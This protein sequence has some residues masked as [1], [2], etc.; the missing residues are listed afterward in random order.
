MQY[1]VYVHSSN[2]LVQRVKNNSVKNDDKIISR[3]T[4]ASFDRIFSR[5]D[6]GENKGR[7]KSHDN[8]NNNKSEE[9][10]SSISRKKRTISETVGAAVQKVRR[11][12]DI[13]WVIALQYLLTVIIYTV[14]VALINDGLS[15]KVEFVFVGSTSA[16]VTAL[17]T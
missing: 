17:L 6:D 12:S 14:F 8:G 15:E 2:V 4:K 11:Q 10:I 16:T 7:K 13:L 9:L 1:D 3:M 5:I